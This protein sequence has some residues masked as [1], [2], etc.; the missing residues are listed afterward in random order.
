MSA[1]YETSLDE[2]RCHKYRIQTI[3][4]AGITINPNPAGGKPPVSIRATCWPL[5]RHDPYALLHMDLQLLWEI[6]KL[7]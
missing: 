3:S 5:P 1:I 2:Q 4:F 7:N 6:R